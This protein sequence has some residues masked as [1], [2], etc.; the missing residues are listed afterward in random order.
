MK[1]KLFYFPTFQGFEQVQSALLQRLE[2]LEIE[3]INL[4]QE[5]DNQRRK[6]EKCLD[7]VAHQVVR[8][9]LSQKVNNSQSWKHCR[10]I[11]QFEILLKDPRIR[12]NRKQ[13]K[14]LPMSSS[15]NLTERVNY[16]DTQPFRKFS[17]ENS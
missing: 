11:L 3:N 16:L 13:S 14:Y 12:L 15:I 10:K 6:Y 1:D 8:A 4:R 2:S 7:D 17:T 5:S 9:I